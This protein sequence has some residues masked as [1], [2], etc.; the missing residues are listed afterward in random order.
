MRLID[1]V[2]GSRLGSFLLAFTSVRKAG[3]N[4]AAP[5]CLAVACR[6]ATHTPLQGG[7]DVVSFTRG[8]QA[9]MTCVS[10]SR[11]RIF[12][13]TTFPP[14]SHSCPHR[15][16]ANIASCEF[17]LETANIDSCPHRLPANTA[18]LG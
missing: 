2:D 18:S 13:P 16:P 7:G 12:E 6:G 9:T 15:L 17:N 11:A 3:A 5:L 1:C 4:R 10:C 14:S 8:T